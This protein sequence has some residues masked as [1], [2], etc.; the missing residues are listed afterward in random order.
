M[1]TIE[2]IEL[3]AG[4][5][6]ADRQRQCAVTRMV[7]PV[8][9]LI[10]FVAGPEGLVPDLKRKLP[11]R[12]VWVTGRRHLVAEAAKRGV[13]ARALKAGV[14]VPLDLADMV[15]RLLVRAGLDALAIAH[16]AGQ[17]AAGYAKVEKVIAKGGLVGLIHAADAGADGTRKLDAALARGTADDAQKVA[18]IRGFRSTE[19]DLALGRPN[20]VHAALLAGRASETFLARWRDLERFR[21]VDDGEDR[22]GEIAGSPTAVTEPL[23]IG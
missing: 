5:R 2:T 12:G 13:F 20:V 10:R 22:R 1:T 9:E 7:R 19:L 17:V 15:E 11:G 3:D 8:D 14:K 6:S 21:M 18:I 23:G 16:K 4:P